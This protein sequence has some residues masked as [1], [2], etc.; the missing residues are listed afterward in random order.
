MSERDKE[1][2]DILA[3]RVNELSEDLAKS[4]AEV[5]ALKTRLSEVSAWAIKYEAL[6][7]SFNDHWL[8]AEEDV[9]RINTLQSLKPITLGEVLWRFAQPGANIRDIIDHL[10]DNP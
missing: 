3:D 10:G 4:K 2:V 6:G 7:R 9:R 8:A 5:S 1:M